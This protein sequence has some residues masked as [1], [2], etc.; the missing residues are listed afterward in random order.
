[1]RNMPPGP[2]PAGHSSPSPGQ[3]LSGSPPQLTLRA[4][5]AC[6][7]QSLEAMAS[8]SD[9]HVHAVLGEASGEIEEVQRGAGEASARGIEDLMVD[10]FKIP[11]RDGSGGWRYS[12]PAA[13]ADVTKILRWRH[14]ALR[15]TRADI[16]P[17]AL[18]KQVQRQHFLDWLNDPENADVIRRTNEL[19]GGVKNRIARDLLSKHRTFCYERFGGREWAH[20]LIAFGRLDD[21]ILEAANEASAEIRQRIRE[22]KGWRWVSEDD[23]EER[24]AS[25][26]PRGPVMGIQHKSSHAKFLRESAKRAAKDLDRANWE[27]QFGIRYMSCPEWWA[28]NRRVESLW[29]AAERAS[30]KAGVP[31]VGRDGEM[32]YPGP[33]EPMCFVGLAIAKYSAKREARGSNDIGAA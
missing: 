11:K 13:M 25:A 7:S 12:R 24:R 8:A 21:E 1:M 6:L 31:Y 32:K 3:A 30:Q 27:W 23:M 4:P 29:S 16:L 20:L 18:Q 19:H 14:Q 26:P 2:G 15:G 5:P 22:E 9:F 17:M 10:M 33:P 28:L